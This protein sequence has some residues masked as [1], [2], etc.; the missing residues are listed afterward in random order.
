MTHRARFPLVTMMVLISLVGVTGIARVAGAGDAP[1][2]KVRLFILSGQSNMKGVDPGTSFTPAVQKA[3]PDDDCVIVH[4]AYS[5][6]LIRTWVK[7]WKLPEGADPAPARGKNGVHYQ[8]LI[9]AIT[10]AMKDK[11]A[12]VSITFCWMQGEADSNHKGYGSVYAAALSSLIAQ[13]KTDLNR[14]DIDI[15]IG[16]IS[17]YGNN[18]PDNRPDWNV[19]RDAQVAWAK[20]TPRAT[21]FDT[22]DLNGPDNGLHYGKEGWK[23]LG[24]RFAAKSIE[25]IQS[26]TT[27]PAKK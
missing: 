24:E 18:D 22:D 10:A 4:S 26:P 13:L 17:D 8:Q 9:D 12:P 23:K 11:P 20:Q 5:G 14:Q 27:Q 1:A 3:F 21:W 16:R 19:V 15:V 6:Q 25:L 7:D 2:K